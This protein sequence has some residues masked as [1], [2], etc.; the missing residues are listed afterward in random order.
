MLQ[1]VVHGLLPRCLAVIG[2]VRLL[3]SPEG[4]QHLYRQ[5]EAANANQDGGDIDPVGQI[6]IRVCRNDCAYPQLQ[7]ARNR[8]GQTPSRCW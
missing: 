3:S 1:V 8:I 7:V 5:Q 4:S 2:F 6:L